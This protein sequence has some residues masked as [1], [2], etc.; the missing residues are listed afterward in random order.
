MEKQNV[1]LTVPKEL[2]RK[3]K[4]IAFERQLSLSGLL[5]KALTELIEHE[6]RYAEAQRRQLNWL[7]EGFDFG[8][9]GN[10]DWKRDDLYER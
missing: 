4:R 7:E 10:I 2:L 9:Q 6:D 1:T 8:L 3:A 5:V